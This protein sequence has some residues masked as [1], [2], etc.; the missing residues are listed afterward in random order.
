MSRSETVNYKLEHALFSEYPQI[1]KESWQ[2]FDDVFGSKATFDQHTNVVTA[3]RNAFKHN[4]ELS[5]SELASAE[6]GLLWF[7]DCLRHS[8]VVQDE[9]VSED[10]VSVD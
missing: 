4:R 2:L 3:T 8:H 10:A 1:I 6:A 9:E 7:E 5:G